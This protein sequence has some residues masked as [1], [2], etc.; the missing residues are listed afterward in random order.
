MDTMNY[1]LP[2]CSISFLCFFSLLIA[3]YLIF[4][5]YIPPIPPPLFFAS[6]FSLSRKVK[7]KAYQFCYISQL[8]REKK[9][10]LN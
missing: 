9:I 3:L 10:I 8:I 5:L 1:E 7:V 4:L 6:H 2:T